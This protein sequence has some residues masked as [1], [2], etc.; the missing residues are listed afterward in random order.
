MEAQRDDAPSAR[1][2]AARSC[3]DERGFRAASPTFDA[4]GFAVE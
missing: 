1:P 4:E 3:S 2:G